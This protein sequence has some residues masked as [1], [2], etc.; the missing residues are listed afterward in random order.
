MVAGTF[1]MAAWSLCLDAWACV[2]C[3]VEAHYFPTFQEDWCC[4]TSLAAVP[5]PCLCGG[6]KSCHLPECL[7]NMVQVTR[8][9]HSRSNFRRR[10]NKLPRD[11]QRAPQGSYQRLTRP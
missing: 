6:T 11:P 5:I 4:S 8:A 3:S 2:L 1:Q 10:Q 9:A 7:L